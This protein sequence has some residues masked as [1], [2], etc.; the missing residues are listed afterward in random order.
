MPA[1]PRDAKGLL[2]AAIEDDNP[3][4]FLEHRWL[5]G[6]RD[7]V[8]SEYYRTPIGSARVIREGKD[9]TVV[10][11]SYMTIEAIR[12]ADML[13]KE[14]IQVEVVDLRSVKPWDTGTVLTSARKTGRLVVADTGWHSFGIAAE[15]VSTVV[16]RAFQDMK[17]AP[18]R[19]TLPDCPSPTSPALA[20]YFYPRAEDI[21]VEVKR[22]LGILTG[23]VRPDASMIKVLDK[24]DASF[25][26]PF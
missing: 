26:G 23:S 5:H 3:V 17:A 1:T 7:E 20:A 13:S 24:P 8:P 12:A 15:I 11:V 6:L 19:I 18:R 21:V 10:A 4:V 9:V 22:T 16:E 14:G 2:I 25:T